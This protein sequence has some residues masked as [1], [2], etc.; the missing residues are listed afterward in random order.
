MA[1][2]N[3]SYRIADGTLL[4]AVVMMNNR[5][6]TVTTPITPAA[7]AANTNNY[8]PTGY[9]TADTI[10][11][12]A[13]AH[14]LLTGISS[15]GI[16]DQQVITLNNVGTYTITLRNQSASS[17][18]ANRFSF[19][20]DLPLFPGSYIQIRYS[21]TTSRWLIHDA[22]GISDLSCCGLITS[23]YSD[24]F[25]S[26]IP[27]LTVGFSGTASSC[28]PVA[29]QIDSRPG[30][31]QG[32]TG[33]TNAGR[34]GIYMSGDIAGATLSQIVF[35]GTDASYHRFRCGLRVP[36]LSTAGE[37]YN[38][39]AGFSDTPAAVG[40]DQFAFR[41]THSLN[42]GNVTVDVNAN[43]VDNV[44]TDTTV[45]LVA[46]TWVDLSLIVLPD[47]SGE[48]SINGSAPVAVAAGSM[49]S[50]SARSTSVMAAMFK[51]NGTTARQLDIDYIEY[52]TW[53]AVMARVN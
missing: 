53:R 32:A 17:T 15:S 52:T 19:P 4:P 47:G 42:A 8:A 20:Y 9:A 43:S 24:C 26:T 36:T 14:Y 48:Y 5:S 27:G 10:R 30:I 35:G 28:A 31:I 40:V 45:T 51:T 23:M 33:S 11:M 13:T 50:G 1:L 37:T 49:P 22:P 6:G 41:Y 18:A 39:I 46:N 12:S 7:L 21:T 16:V 29:T 2:V 34:C 38:I 44:T 3:K 25:S